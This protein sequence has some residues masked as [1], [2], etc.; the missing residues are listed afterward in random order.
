L[1]TVRASAIF[2]LNYHC[3]RRGHSTL[4]AAKQWSGLI[5]DYYAARC[6]IVL[7]IALADAA[8]GNQ[9]NQSAVN[10]GAGENAYS[11]QK[12][13]KRYPQA[14]TEDALEISRLLLTKY[15][16]YFAMC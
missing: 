12:S 8:A 3:L 7:D 6:S 1:Q 14:P 10:F 11:F 5:R 15:S 2:L 13:T 4:K 16:K 9:L